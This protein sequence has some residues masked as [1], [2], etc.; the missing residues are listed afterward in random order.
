MIEIKNMNGGVIHTVDADTL[1]GANLSGAN[2]KGANLEGANLKG[3]YLKGAYLEGANL[4]D[5]NLKGADFTHAGLSGANL[6]YADLQDAT[7]KY[8][9]LQDATFRGANL[10]GTNIEDVYPEYPVKSVINDS[11]IEKNEVDD[12]TTKTPYK[13]LIWDISRFD[14]RGYNDKGQI[15]A[16][17]YKST[18]NNHYSVD[19]WDFNR[20]NFINIGCFINEGSAYSAVENYTLDEN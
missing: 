12:I 1:V 19:I 20:T 13:N 6:K 10:M 15:L 8:A 11:S 7:L 9:Y 17:M 18:E 4:R 14:Y 16:K 5:A 3:A 2:L